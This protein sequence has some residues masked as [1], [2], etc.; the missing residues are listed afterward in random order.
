LVQLC[1]ISA[2]V[3]EG[4]RQAGRLPHLGGISIW[5]VTGPSVQSAKFTSSKLLRLEAFWRKYIQACG[6][7]LKAFSPV[8]VN[9]GGDGH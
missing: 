6:G 3:V 1:A 8:L 5:F 2:G 9:F 4:E 7:D